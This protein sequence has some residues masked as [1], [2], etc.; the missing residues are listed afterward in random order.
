MLESQKRCIT[1]GIH[2][3]VATCEEN[4]ARPMLYAPL[5]TGR[6]ELKENDSY[7]EIELRL[8]AVLVHDNDRQANM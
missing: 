6:T 7:E 5:A 3:D 1:K 4:S 2:Q 8:N